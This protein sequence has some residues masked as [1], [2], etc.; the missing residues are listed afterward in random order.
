M[1][2]GIVIGLLIIASIIAISVAV[3]EHYKTRAILNHIN[4]MI[5][6][7][8]NGNFTEHIIDESL[9]SEVECKMS[10]YLSA[11]E[12]S[13]RNVAEEKKVLNSLIS[14]ISHQTKTPLANIK[15]YA[16]LLKEADLQ[17][18][19]ED[20]IVRLYDQTEKLEF[21][22]HT[23]VEMSRLETGILKLQPK[24]CA[25]N[26]LLR[27]LD[28]QYS[29]IAREKGLQFSVQATKLTAVF[30]E[31]WTAEAIGNIVDNAIKYTDKG[32]VTIKAKGFEMFQCI[33]IADT[34]NGIKESEQGKIFGRFQR[35]QDVSAREGLGLGLY[36]AREIIRRQNGYI[37]VVSKE[38]E[39]AAFQVYLPT[40]N[41]IFQN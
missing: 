31:K 8:I 11:S 13:A 39:G 30:D 26:E 33:E 12:L 20:D 3:Y 37:K 1:G 35:S 9:L 25:M 29:V 21:L 36:L 38:G 6:A 14:D 23:L 2:K 10:K 15:L 4:D 5:E 18:E 40:G 27:R 34:G 17:Q 19:N 41:Q 22:I 28:E 16:E 24:E 7:A 32:S